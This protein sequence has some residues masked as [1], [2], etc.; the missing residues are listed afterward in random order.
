MLAL[1][2]TLLLSRWL[3]LS[4]LWRRRV[5][6]L[7][8]GSVLFAL[9]SPAHGCRVTVARRCGATFMRHVRPIGLELLCVALPPAVLDDLYVQAGPSCAGFL[10]VLSH[11]R[12]Q[13]SSR[14]YHIIVCRFPLGLIGFE[15]FH[16]FGSA[17]ERA[18]IFERLR[19]QARSH[20][21]LLLRGHAP[22]FRQRPPL[23]ADV[24]I[25]P[26]YS[27]V[28]HRTHRLV[29]RGRSCPTSL[30]GSGLRSRH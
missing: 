29:V 17:M 1:H 7:P 13:V 14:S 4:K 25:V 12:V 28:G 2:P 26:S 18:K 19:K 15:L 6:L 27:Q 24:P 8:R 10:S 20:Q 21:M 5:A 23:M 9:R 11:H 16:N 3:P 30:D 22:H